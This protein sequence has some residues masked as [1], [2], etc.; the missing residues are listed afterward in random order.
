ML[1][2]TQMLR[3]Y[4]NVNNITQNVNNILNWFKFDKDCWNLAYQMIAFHLCT[5]SILPQQA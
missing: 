1:D 4:L 5:M 2:C 3:I